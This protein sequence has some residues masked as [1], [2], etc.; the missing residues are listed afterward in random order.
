MGYVKM[1]VHLQRIDNMKNEISMTGPMRGVILLAGILQGGLYYLIKAHSPLFDAPQ[2]HPWLAFLLF[3]ILLV[4]ATLAF[5]GRSL[6]QTALWVGIALLV[7]VTAAHS[8]WISWNIHGLDG[9]EPGDKLRDYQLFLAAIL[10]LALPW[11]QNVLAR[12]RIGDYPPIFAFYWQNTLITLLVL[13]SVGMMWSVLWLGASLFKLI[14]INFFQHLFFN[15]EEFGYIFT[16]GIAA[17]AIILCRNYAHLLLSVQNLL[18]VVAGA[19]LPVVALILTMFMLALPVTGLDALS[20]KV[21]GAGLLNTLCLL[22]LLL[23]ALVWYPGREASPYPN[24]LRRF[25]FIPLFLTPVCSAVA[26]WAIWV[27]VAQ[28]GWTPDRLYAALATLVLLV[29]GLSYVLVVLSRQRGAFSWDHA[30]RLVL[31]MVLLL[32]V[33]SRTP[34]LDPYRISVNSQMARFTAEKKMDIDTVYMLSHSLR[35]GKDALEMLSNAPE[36]RQNP[37]VYLAI[38]NRLKKPGEALGVL[39][40]EDFRKQVVLIMP[41]PQPEEGVWK[42]LRTGDL[43]WIT[44]CEPVE[45]QPGCALL[46]Q[47]LNDDG[48]PEWVFFNFERQQAAV[49][50]KRDDNWE[51]VGR[52]FYAPDS[53]NAERLKTLA[54]TNSITTQ[55]RQWRNLS[56][57]DTLLEFLEVR[58]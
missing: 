11:L 38:Q 21:S 12:K 48:K 32:T 6:R 20:H 2:D 8:A 17:M 43:S 5:A 49:L 33:A 9:W 45:G 54:G 50:T 15:S 29:W 52:F 3:T 41:S 34:L 18:T 53:L 25:I 44:H 42:A 28:Y 39:S 56:L 27:R 31:M 10:F 1:P 47:D 30:G 4:P 19:L 58:Q 35:R 14:G 24:A 13:F 37:Q 57:G 36:I 26:A 7:L 55:P 51:Y 40:V 16:C 22:F 23:M 46:A